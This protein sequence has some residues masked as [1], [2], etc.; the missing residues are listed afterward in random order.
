MN[1]VV[2]W[3]FDETLGYFRPLE[4]GFLGMPVPAAMRPARLKPG[5]E[6]LL[7][8][9]REFTHVVTTAALGEYARRVLR[10]HGLLEY[11]SAVLGREDGICA[12]EGKDYGRV[13]ER[14]GIAEDDLRRRLV[15]VGNDA[16]RDPDFRCRQV[17]MLHDARM[18]DLPAAPLATALRGLAREGDGDIKRG[19]DRFFECKAFPLEG[20][21][22]LKAEYWGS[23][24]E[25]RVHPVVST[26]L[27]M[28]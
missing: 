6:A 2:C 26:I 10:D 19:F 14:F 13:G 4:F 20:N 5:I 7:D 17:V 8:S 15:I 23:Y 1:P 3:D 25:N 24:A 12:G 28:C 18:M 16:E 22:K 11:F 21:L 9:L 27:P